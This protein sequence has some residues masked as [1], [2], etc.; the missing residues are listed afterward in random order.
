MKGFLVLFLAV[1]VGVQIGRMLEGGSKPAAAGG[2]Q[3]GGVTKCSSQNGDVNADG[4]V[5]LS[6]AVTI[7]GNLFLGSPTQLVPLC[8]QPAAPSGLPDT[9]QTKCYDDQSREIP[10]AGAT[11][12]GQDGHYATGCPSEG[13]FTDNGDGTVTDH[14][15]GLMWQKDTADVNGDG[16]ADGLQWCDAIAYCE[17]LTLGGGV[18]AWDDWRLPNVRELQSIV[19]YGRQG[20]PIDPVF[21][22]QV[23]VGAFL[24]FYWSSTL[25]VDNPNAAWGVAFGIGGGYLDSDGQGGSH[26]VRAVRNA[27]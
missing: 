20:P 7:L 21:I 12:L 14:C 3:G 5:D 26:Y 2:G 10:C 11:C 17:N 22:A 6:D 24:S 23:E 8:P 1:G 16:I 19:D 25:Y 4:K 27:P 13:R 9:G 15:T 18:A